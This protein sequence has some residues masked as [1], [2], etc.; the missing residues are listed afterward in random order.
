MQISSLDI[1]GLK[2]DSHTPNK[3]KLYVAWSVSI[4]GIRAYSLAGMLSRF[5]TANDK[6]LVFALSGPGFISTDPEIIRRD[7]KTNK[8]TI[9]FLSFQ[10]MTF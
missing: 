5:Q 2:E 9:N 7:I 4:K 10:K 1:S 8:K 6:W 3:S